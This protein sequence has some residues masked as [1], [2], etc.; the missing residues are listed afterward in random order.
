MKGINYQGASIISHYDTK[1]HPVKNVIINKI[2]NGRVN[3]YKV[4]E[5]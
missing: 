3:F 4:I 5:P 2:E 1:R